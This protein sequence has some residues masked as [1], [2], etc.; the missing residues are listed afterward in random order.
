MIWRTFY[1]VNENKINTKVKV[2]YDVIPDEL[3]ENY[4]EN[5]LIGRFFKIL[6][7]RE[8]EYITLN[9]YLKSLMIEL[10]G[11]KSLIVALKYDANFL[12]LLSIIQY[13]I[14]NPDIDVKTYKREVF[15]CIDIIK[16]LQRK[17][18]LEN[19]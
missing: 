1:V 18:K 6:C 5:I 16:K 14:E 19:E 4:L 3:F 13:F 12:V 11:S 17:Y 2:N 7:M 9:E 10:K 8:K 15:K